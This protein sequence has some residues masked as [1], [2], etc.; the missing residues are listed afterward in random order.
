ERADENE[1]VRLGDVEELAVHLLVGDDDRLRH[2]GCDGV[3]GVDR[4]DDLALATWV[5]PPAEV[6]G[7]PHQPH[8]DLRLVGRVEGDHSHPGE[9][10]R[11][12]P[13]DDRVR[14]L[15]VRGVAP[16]GQDVGCGEHRLC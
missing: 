3:A 10:P 8:E 14:Y 16:P 7:R 15:V 12:N 6:A 1:V 2:T 13:V 11:V 4:P 5:G 9:D